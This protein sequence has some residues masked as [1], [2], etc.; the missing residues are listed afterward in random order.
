MT[1]QSIMQ[2]SFNS[3]EWAPALNARVDIAKYHSGAALLRN[4]FVDYRGGAT[5]KPGS[6]YILQTKST[7]NVRLIPFQASLAVSYALEFGQGYLRFYN[8]GAPVLEVATTISGA[9]QA[10]PGIITDVAHGYATGDWIQIA[11]VAG[12]TQLNGN[13]YIVVKLTANT[14]SLTDL[15]GVAVNTTGFGAYI[16]GGTAQRIYTIVSPYLDHELAQLKFTQNV[17]L[18]I[19]C[20]P[21]YPPYQLTLISATNWTLAAIVFGSTILAP[22]GLAFTTTAGAGTI[23]YS[24]VV[25]AVDPNGQE[26]E[27]S[28]VVN[29]GAVGDIRTAGSNSITW[30]AAAGAVSYNVYRAEIRVGGAVPGGAAFGFVGNCFGLQFIDTNIAPDFAQ[31]PPIAQ[32]PFSGSGV[33]SIKIT[34]GGNYNGIAAQ[35]PTV[36]FTGVFTIIPQAHAVCI[37]ATAA[38]A[39]AGNFYKLGDQV[40]LFGLSGDTVVVTGI[41]AFG[42]I[43]SIALQNVGAR[44]TSFVNNPVAQAS[45]S[46]SGSGATFNITYTVDSVVVDIAGAVTGPPPGV[47]F[48]AGA[49]TATATATLGAPSTGNPTVPGF[50][51]QRLVLAGPVGNPQQFNMS[52]PGSYYNFDTTDPTQPDNAITGTLVSGQLNTIQSMIAQPQGL[53]VLSDKQAWLLNGGSPGSPLSATSISANSQAYNGSAFPPPIVAND[54][55]LYVQSKGAIVRDLVFNYYTQVYTGT[56]ISVLSSHLFYG[57][58]VLEWAWAEEPYKLVWAVRNDGQ[59]LLLTFLK[60][61]ELIAWTHCDTQGLYKSVASITETISNNTVDAIYT[62]VQRV[63]N[64]NTIQYVERIIDLAYPVGATDA[65]QVDAGIQYNGAATLAFVGAQHLAGATVTGL[66]TDDLGNVTVITPFAMPTTGSF[67]LP[68]PTPVGSTGYTRVTIGLA[69]TPQLQTLQLDIGEPTIQGTYKQITAVTARCNQTLGLSIGRTFNTLVPMKDLI[70]GNVGSATNT[71]VTDLVTGDART[72][73]DASWT[74][75]GQYCIQQSNPYPASILG[76]IPE[77]TTYRSK[78]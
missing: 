62:V 3:G 55:I 28:A 16:S 74:V 73:I 71:K 50:F 6:R 45:T 24:Y 27:V 35:F 57:F 40:A 59:M 7:S 34:S 66:A 20:H 48:S 63:I 75:P 21:N 31:P 29:S 11:N 41:G 46:G 51:D 38:V 42:N 67:T 12:M 33:T 65:W 37:I 4:F 61:Q 19:I 58:K 72:I 39:T 49:P 56:D 25:T 9:S 1:A 77:I 44:F 47:V 78:S 17:N 14:Y 43:T 2:Y 52:Q 54:N 13:Y 30:V 70:V 69:F 26:S 18:L 32:S 64:G 36:S 23:N 8:N 68:A 60:E 76:V 5:T 22:T 15:N 10:N 53:I